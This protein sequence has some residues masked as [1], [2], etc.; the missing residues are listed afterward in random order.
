MELGAAS[1]DVVETVWRTLAGSQLRDAVTRLPEAQR[2][3]IELAYFQGLTHR[4]IA[5]KLG[6]PIGTVHTRAQTA[7]RD[8]R[9]LL[10]PLHLN[11]A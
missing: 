3:V 4:E 9:I 6:Q 11:E 10:T 2:K 8:L 5:E 7:L 1:P